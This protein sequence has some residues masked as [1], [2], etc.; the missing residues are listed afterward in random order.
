MGLLGRA[1]A[2]SSYPVIVNPPA[3]SAPQNASAIALPTLY[4]EFHPDVQAQ[5]WTGPKSTRS[6]DSSLLTPHFTRKD[7]WHSNTADASGVDNRPSDLAWDNLELL[8]PVVE[9][10]RVAVGVP[11]VIS[12][13]YRNAKTNALV[14]GVPD[15][16]HTHGLAVDLVCPGMPAKALRDKFLA[17]G[18]SF[19]QAIWE[20]HGNGGWLHLAIAGPGQTPRNQV[21]DI[22]K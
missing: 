1:P 9:A 6:E 14:G 8:A 15:S 12:S 7:F 10:L 3:P 4:P 11:L 21:F 13:G 22:Y 19:D 20:G 5:K 18:V 2:Y 16:A 17:L